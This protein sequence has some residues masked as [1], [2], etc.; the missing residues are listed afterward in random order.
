MAYIPREIIPEISFAY[1]CLSNNETPL[2]V[3]LVG[4]HAYGLAND[5]SDKDYLGVHYVDTEKLFGLGANELTSTT[6]TDSLPDFASH[7][8]LKF[9]RLTMGGNPTVSELLWLEKYEYISFEFEELI[10]IRTS[11]LCTKKVKASYGGYVLQQAKRLMNRLDA[12]KDGF[13]PDLRK[14]TRKHARHCVRLL[15][16]CETLLRT[17]HLE[18]NVSDAKD[19]IFQIGEKAET[20]PLTFYNFVEEKVKQLDNINSVLPDHID[21]ERIENWLINFREE[22]YATQ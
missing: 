22:K 20:D 1:G 5:D 16:Q 6:R 9:I 17:G 21:R 4:S 11:F 18:V 7:E 13:D 14:R 15:M 8:I 10:A 3:G 19:E 2:V 12:G